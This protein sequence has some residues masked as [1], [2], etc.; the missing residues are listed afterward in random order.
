MH[1]TVGDDR[2]YQLCDDDAPLYPAPPVPKPD[3]YPYNDMLH[4]SLY[5]QAFE[6]TTKIRHLK[7]E[8]DCLLAR[9]SEL[10]MHAMS[11]E[12]GPDKYV[13]KCEADRCSDLWVLQ[14]LRLK[15]LQDERKQ[16]LS[17]IARENMRH[18]NKNMNPLHVV[19][20]RDHNGDYITPPGEGSS[21]QQ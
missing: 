11:L 18:D 9:A 6:L 15:A 2:P 14:D 8:V 13:A 4:A 21:T 1:A 20:N 5:D 12:E 3:P 17:M 16:L 19:W 7:N 10:D